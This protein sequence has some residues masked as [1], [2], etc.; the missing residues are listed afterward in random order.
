M[1]E[2]EQIVTDY[3][4]TEKTDYAIMI[5]GDWGS[6]KTYYVKNTLFKEIN[7][8]DS[9]L[10][11]KDNP[12]KYDPVYISLF[13]LR[14]TN[15]ILNKILLELNPWLKKKHGIILRTGLEQISSIFNLSIYKS[16][17]LKNFLSIFNIP[18]NKVLFIDDLERTDEL[19][20]PISSI[21]GQINH[22]T[23]QENLKVIIVCNSDQTQEIFSS[24]NEKTIRF[25]C[26][27]NPSLHEVYDNLIKTYKDDYFSFVEINKSLIIDIFNNAHYKNL[28][29]LRFI[30]DI[31]QKIHKLVKNKEYHEEILRRFLTF[32]V[33]YSIEY[34]LNTKSKDNL[35]SLK[36]I[37][38]FD[39]SSF[40]IA[41]L[42]PEIHK[43][44]EEEVK[45]PSYTE[46]FRTKYSEFIESFYYSQ[47]IADYIQN[48]YLDEDKLLQVITDLIQEIK[49]KE[50]TK[51]TKLINKI[52]NWRNLDD[53]EFEPLKEE[54][55]DKIGEGKFTLAAYPIIFAEFLKM[56]HYQLYG[57]DINESFMALFTRG[58]DL[59]KES[60]KYDESLR[61][62]LPHWSISDNPL[63][64]KKYDRIYEYTIQ[65][66]QETQTKIF[67]T[68]IESIYFWI[69]NNNLDEL[70]SVLSKPDYLNHPILRDI[71]TEKL[72]RLLE[73]ANPETIYALHAGIYRRYSDTDIRTGGV[74]ILSDEREFFTELHHLVSE[75][76]SNTEKRKISIVSFIDLQS[77]LKR[78]LPAES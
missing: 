47:E 6:G 68:I 70:E 32:S 67:N 77:N 63:I 64:K 38:P 26:L 3:L 66:N 23:E 53:E 31:F 52:R 22:F 30:L 8:K 5:N 73:K 44:K 35:D 50:E 60:H 75:K 24:T 14:D 12:Q 65:A 40:D 42:F 71:D 69:E 28:R 25:S 55:L 36:D 17:E 37:G 41:K 46:K 29:T 56:E 15:D 19:R 61:I 76:I 20:L 33:I 51:E 48:G 1:K 10:K 11:N 78:F 39:L 18:K 7:K 43:E 62:K 49:S 45:E 59:A 4:S 27:Y 54:I 13:G 74:S 58:I 16:N 9:Y 21:L 2:I 57:L 72:F 34:K